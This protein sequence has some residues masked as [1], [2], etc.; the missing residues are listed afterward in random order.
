M[1]R[2]VGQAMLVGSAQLAHLVRELSSI[3]VHSDN[4]PWTAP[5]HVGK[6]FTT[7][8]YNA[9]GLVPLWPRD[10][11]L[12]HST[13]RGLLSG[14]MRYPRQ[15]CQEMAAVLTMTSSPNMTHTCDGYE[16]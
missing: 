9:T 11:P 14:V 8:L 10:A 12:P 5:S 4:V 3:A 15:L 2:A 16:C 1:R 13:L 7:E 6:L